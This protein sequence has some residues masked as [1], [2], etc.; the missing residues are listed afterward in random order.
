MA[1]VGSR[2]RVGV[3]AIVIA[4]AAAACAGGAPG[5]VAP[6]SSSVA[7]P[8]A[9]GSPRA[10]G[11]TIDGSVDAGASASDPFALQG[12]LRAETPPKPPSARVDAPLPAIP[13]GLP[14]PP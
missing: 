13:R 4:V 3:T 2:A 12:T 5:A 10:S 14:P 9:N 6:S 1:A 8:P 7:P 11:G